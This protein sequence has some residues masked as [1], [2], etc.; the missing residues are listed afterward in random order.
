MRR[1]VPYM[2]VGLLMTLTV[3][4][5]AEQ[6]SSSG[7][8]A[9]VGTSEPLKISLDRAKVDLKQHRLELA[10]SREASKVT[11]K[12]M[13]EGGAVLDEH[14]TAFPGKPAGSALVMTWSPSTEAAVARI[15]LR[16][17]DTHG[18][19]VG[20]ALLPWSVSIPHKDVTFKTGSAQI[21]ETEKPKLEESFAKIAEVMAR[22]KEIG[23]VTLFVAGHTDTV[24][25]EGE[26]LRLSRARAQSI[27][28]WFRTH[29]IK[30]PIA[31]EGF[32]VHA[33]LVKTAENVDEPRNRR[34]D[35]ILAFDEPAIPASGFRPSWQRMK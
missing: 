35:Y 16:A 33:L 21:D 27:A 1:R 22:Q 19:W 32:G 28:A 23:K 18:Y 13:D 2:V 9:E 11:I 25:T 12:V 15:E 26:N 7:A 31:F 10:L 8:P 34:V 24:G 29:G 14:E 20:V 17:F 30:L 5:H 4:A 6:G 3:A